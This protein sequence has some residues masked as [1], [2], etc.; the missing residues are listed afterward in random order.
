MKCLAVNMYLHMCSY[1]HAGS[2]SNEGEGLE[3]FLCCDALKLNNLS[4]Q[5]A[6]KKMLQS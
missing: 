3:W 1:I 2:T 5:P 4:F 6:L